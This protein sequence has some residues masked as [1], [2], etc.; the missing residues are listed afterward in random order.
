MLGL[1][2]AGKNQ[3]IHV[4]YGDGELLEETGHGL[5]DDLGIALIPYPP[6]F[7]HI[8]E[9][10]LGPSIVIDKIQGDRIRAFKFGDDIPVAHQQ[11]GG[12]VPEPHLIKIGGF[13]LPFVR[14]RDQDLP[15]VPGL[16]G[17]QGRDQGTGTG[18]KGG[19]EILALQ[20][21]L[22]I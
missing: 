1:E 6:F 2:E 3:F 18:T 19:S 4:G 22:K 21:I 7:P 17:R 5:G 20:V 10:V 8:V 16:D 12:P 11:G 9:F 13:G 15:S 14:S